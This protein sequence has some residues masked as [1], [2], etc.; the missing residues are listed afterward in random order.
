MKDCDKAIWKKGEHVFSIYDGGSSAD[1][2]DWVKIIAKE[3]GQRVDWHYFGGVAVVKVI[4]DCDKV[5]EV[6]KKH[7]PFDMSYRFTTDNDSVI[8]M[9]LCYGKGDK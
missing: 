3:S 1:I 4:G 9:Q 2:D 6:I 7:I 8:P 5:R